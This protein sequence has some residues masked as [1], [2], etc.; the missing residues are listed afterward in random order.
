V[1]KQL[2]ERI[3]AAGSEEERERLRGLIGKAGVANAKIAYAR[4]KEITASERWQSL[5]AEGA[6]VQRCLWAST[7]TK[8][9]SYRDVIYVEELIGPDTINT[10]PQTTLDAFRDH[11]IVRQTLDE[12]VEGA[13]A[14]IRRLAAE[15]IDFRA[16]TDDLQTQG[17]ELFSESFRKAY[18][19]VREKRERTIAEQGGVG[20]TARA[21]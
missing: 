3:A 2:E 10:M 11:G 19:T 14:H 21:E 1:D 4:F 9:P 15:G 20:A 16:L 13:F 7:S 5:A 6:R 12:D 17:V 8:N 18:D